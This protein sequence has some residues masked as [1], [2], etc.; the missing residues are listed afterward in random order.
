VGLCALGCALAGV[1]IGWGLLYIFSLPFGMTS[2]TIF[3]S[4][5]LWA[6]VLGPIVLAPSLQLL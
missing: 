3:A 2:F 1:L 5:L 4:D 6:I